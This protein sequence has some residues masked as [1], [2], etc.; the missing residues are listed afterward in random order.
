M[1]DARPIPKNKTGAAGK[2]DQFIGAVSRRYLRVLV[3]LMQRPRTREAI[4]R[5]AGASN[6]PDIIRRLRDRGL[7]IPCDLVPC[8]DRD[9]R[10]VKRGIYSMTPDDLARIRAWRRRRD[11]DRRKPPTQ[12]DLPGVAE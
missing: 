3:S 10:E 1:K 6:G 8:I 12:D 4:D 9:G 2:R 5:V 7:S 11:A